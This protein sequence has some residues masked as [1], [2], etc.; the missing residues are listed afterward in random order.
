MAQHPCAGRR[1]DDPRACDDIP[2]GL[3]TRCRDL[4]AQRCWQRVG[5]RCAMA[6]SGTVRARDGAPGAY[7][8]VFTAFLEEA[9]ARRVPL[10][11]PRARDK[12]APRQT[13]SRDGAHGAY[14]DVFTAVPE[15]AI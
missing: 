12:E 14:R 5:T 2:I 10:R 1:G 8:D 7:R 4:R 11:C 15:Q 6:S 9:I 13:E 3:L